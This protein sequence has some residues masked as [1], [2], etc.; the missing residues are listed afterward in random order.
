VPGGHTR[1]VYRLKGGAF[2]V[3]EHLGG[4]IVQVGL[5]GGISKA[6]TFDT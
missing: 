3:I 5:A 4:E 1:I 6:T 2:K